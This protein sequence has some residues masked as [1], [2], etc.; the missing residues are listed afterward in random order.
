VSEPKTVEKKSSAGIIHMLEVIIDIFIGSDE[1]KTI[2][3]R[4]IAEKSKNKFTFR[5]ANE[6]EFEFSGDTDESFD[7]KKASEDANSL[8]DD[9]G[10]VNGETQKRMSATYKR[11]L[12]ALA[13]DPDSEFSKFIQEVSK[14]RRESGIEAHPS[15]NVGRVEMRFNSLFVGAEGVKRFVYTLTH[16]GGDSAK[17]VLDCGR[18]IGSGTTP[19]LYLLIENGKCIGAT[20]VPQRNDTGKIDESL[21]IKDGRGL[22]FGHRLQKKNGE[23]SFV[24]D[25]ISK[26]DSDTKKRTCPWCSSTYYAGDDE[27]KKYISQFPLLDNSNGCEICCKEKKRLTKDGATYEYRSGVIHQ[28]SG[29]KGAM[30]VRVNARGGLVNIR[31][32]NGGNAF[33]CNMCERVVYHSDGSSEPNKCDECQK[34]LCSDCNSSRLSYFNDWLCE[35]CYS[36]KNDVPQDISADDSGT[37]QTVPDTDDKGAPEAASGKANKTFWEIIFG[38]TNKSKD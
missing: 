14:R 37:S 36:S 21:K 15:G 19:Q 32:G 8:L 38:R 3:E 33:F 6:D 13:N 31:K 28:N 4:V 27:Y 1:R 9:L 16:E 34:Y 22:V 35:K 23:Y 26:K 24:W 11:I 7:A 10:K 17:L 18:L 25:F 20:S 5:R 2:I 12:G 29:K 30:F